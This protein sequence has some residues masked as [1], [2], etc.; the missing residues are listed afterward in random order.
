MF[1]LLYFLNKSWSLHLLK[2]NHAIMESF[3]SIFTLL[4]LITISSLSMRKLVL[5]VLP[6]SSS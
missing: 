5:C 1:T 2:K 3:V 6:E 4:N